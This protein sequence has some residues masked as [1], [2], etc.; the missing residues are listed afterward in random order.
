MCDEVWQIYR[1][2]QQRFGGAPA[3]IEW[4][5]D[6]PRLQVLLD[7]AANLSAMAAAPSLETA[8]A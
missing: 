1:Y 7:E 3:L 5:T 4:D 2:A 8:T 6:I